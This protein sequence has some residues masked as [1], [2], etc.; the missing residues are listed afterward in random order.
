MGPWGHCEMLLGVEH[1]TQKQNDW[2]RSWGWV[3]WWMGG[4]VRQ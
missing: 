1:G 4:G 2:R 3:Q